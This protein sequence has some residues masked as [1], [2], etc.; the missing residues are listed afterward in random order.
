MYS[1]NSLIMTLIQ[2]DPVVNTC[3]TVTSPPIRFPT[4]VLKMLSIY[5]QILI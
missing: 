5:W 3:L 2:V 1:Y 4:N